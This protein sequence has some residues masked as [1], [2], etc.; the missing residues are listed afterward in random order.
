MNNPFKNILIPVDLSANNE[1]AFAKALEYASD[2]SSIHLFHVLQYSKAGF[3]GMVQKYFYHLEERPVY[4]Q[5][6]MKLNQ[7]RDSMAKFKKSVNVF[8]WIVEED[9]VQKAIE[10]KAT[11]LNADL[12]MLV[13]QS[14]HTLLPFFNTVNASLLSQNTALPVLSL[15]QG[16]L[17]KQ[18][19]MVV[20]I[21]TYTSSHEKELISII[22]RKFV[23][24]IY[25]VTF[26]ANDEA[27][28]NANASS[29]LQVYKWLKTIH[30]NVEYAALGGAS[31]TK[32]VLNY[33]DRV[34][35]DTL[36][37]HF[38]NESKIKPGKKKVIDLWHR[39]PGYVVGAG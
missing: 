25:L 28:T 17:E 26:T 31:N 15:K 37:F 1:I 11:E 10:N 22:C 32:A 39:E 4:I 19:A 30:I 3:G 18:K 36:L 9:S 23:S 7:W 13:K 21:T 2:G 16:L 24:K 6:E 27:S 34:N 29:L 35:A 38:K 12:I 20:P 33:A 5:A 8:S 14:H